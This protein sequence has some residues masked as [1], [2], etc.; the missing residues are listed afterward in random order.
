MIISHKHK[1]VF[2][3]TRKTAG[4]SIEMALSS[5][6]GT[7]DILTPLSG[8]DELQRKGYSGV[9]KQNYH[10]PLKQLKPRDVV[11]LFKNFKW[12]RYRN[13]D[14]AS[15]VRNRLGGDR[16]KE[17]FT[18][19]FDRQPVEKLCSHYQWL[20]MT[21]QCKTVSEYVNK[22]YYHKIRASLLYLDSNG[23]PMVDKVYRLEELTDALNDISMRLKL[24][25]P[26]QMPDLKS[27]QSVPVTQMERDELLLVYDEVLNRHFKFESQ[28]YS[29]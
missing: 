12:P 19:C 1:F 22:N 9:G 29:P 21:G 23:A 16:W 10:L 11:S 4:T 20:K 3:K 27:K 8:D 7:K 2:I 15:K 5:I 14:N 25:K 28:L 13:H 18:F 17:Y 26:L 6:C 24:D